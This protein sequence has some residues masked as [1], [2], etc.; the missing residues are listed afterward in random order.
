MGNPA[1]RLASATARVDGRHFPAMTPG[2]T[3]R[4]EPMILL[5][6]ITAAAGFIILAGIVFA[7]DLPVYLP[8]ITLA[9][10]VLV[11]LSRRISRFLRVIVGTL[12]GAHILVLALLL[13]KNKA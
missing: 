6:A 9:T 11:F 13:R 8:V 1:A 3:G 5:S 10:A 12:A 7:A 4:S 2:R